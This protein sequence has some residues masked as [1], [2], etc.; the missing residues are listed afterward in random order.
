[1]LR[2][3]WNVSSRMK[4]LYD[5]WKNVRSCSRA[6]KSNEPTRSCVKDTFPDP[7]AVGRALRLSSRKSC[8]T[9]RDPRSSSCVTLLCMLSIDDELVFL[10]FK[11]NILAETT[12]PQSRP[13]RT[14]HLLLPTLKNPHIFSRLI[15]FLFQ[16]CL[17]AYPTTPL[18]VNVRLWTSS[19]TLVC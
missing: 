12:P 19:S 11:M 7:R 15:H 14:A 6:M 16:C 2:V 5:V 8:A 9:Q 13:S 10:F 3:M 18:E 17:C 1:M 4:E